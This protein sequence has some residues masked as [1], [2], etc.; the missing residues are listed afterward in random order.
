ML[1]LMRLIG[2]LNSCLLT[3][4]SLPISFLFEEMFSLFYIYVLSAFLSE[5]VAQITSFKYLNEFNLPAISVLPPVGFPYVFLLFITFYLFL[6]YFNRLFSIDNPDSSLSVTALL[7]PL[8]L[9]TQKVSSLL[10]FISEHFDVNLK[11]FVKAKTGEENIQLKVL[12]F[13]N[14]IAIIQSPYHPPPFL[15]F[16][17]LIILELLP[18]CC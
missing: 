4:M 11:V 1:K 7:E 14:L 10:L 18:I 2:K 17:I 12:D 6:S 13:F 16:L 5:K 15:F 9:A 3:I 8:S